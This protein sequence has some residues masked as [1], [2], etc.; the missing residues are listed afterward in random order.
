MVLNNFLLDYRLV[1]KALDINWECCCY[2]T[3]GAKLDP[4]QAH[5]CYYWRI[6]VILLGIYFSP[7]I[8]LKVDAIGWATKGYDL[9]SFPQI[10]VE[11]EVWSGKTGFSNFLPVF[12]AES[13]VNVVAHHKF[14]ARN[15]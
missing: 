15:T 10:T 5:F 2:W 13:I 3:Q 8:N 14:P 12:F 9:K 6:S 11:K 4:L 7:M 1:E